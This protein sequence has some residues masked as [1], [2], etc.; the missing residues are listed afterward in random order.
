MSL[1][2]GKGRKA[3]VA[4][5]YI[6]TYGWIL[7]AVMALGGMLFYYN[8]SR[9]DYLVPH[10]CSFLSGINCLGSDVEEDLLKISVVNEFGFAIS[11]ISITITGTCNSTANTTDGNPHGNLNVMLANKQTIYTFE[12]QNLTGMEV[13]EH[14]DMSYVN[15][16]SGQPHFKVGKL[17]Y[18]PYE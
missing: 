14:I 16:E 13:V 3:Q 17:E 6:H 15:V 8:I 1:M 7:L 10:G 11:N 2:R 5:E 18:S 4:M 12:C 9:A